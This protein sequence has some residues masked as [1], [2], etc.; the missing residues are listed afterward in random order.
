LNSSFPSWRQCGQKRA[1]TLA[2]NRRRKVKTRT[3][4]RHVADR[5]RVALI[6]IP[7]RQ[8]V[9]VERLFAEIFTRS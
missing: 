1:S 2:A 7:T 5:L 4:A 6:P 9:Q 8:A 3:A